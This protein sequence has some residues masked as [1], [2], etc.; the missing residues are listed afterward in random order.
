MSSPHEIRKKINLF[1]AF[2]VA[3]LLAYIGYKGAQTPSWLFGVL[4]MLG[5]LVH[6]YHLYKFF[7]L[8]K[9]QEQFDDKSAQPLQ[10]FANVKE[11]SGEKAD[12][13]G[14]VMPYGYF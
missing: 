14:S 11:A 13:S 10:P 9:I 1:H 8:S 12:E 7:D 2:V 3:P 5:L 6:F 4:L